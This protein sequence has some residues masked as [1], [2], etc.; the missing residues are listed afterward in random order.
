[1]EIWKYKNMEKGKN[2]ER[3]TLNVKRKKENTEE[4]PRMTPREDECSPRQSPGQAMT[5][6]Q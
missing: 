1:M 5:N 6:N 2:V 3:V 4:G